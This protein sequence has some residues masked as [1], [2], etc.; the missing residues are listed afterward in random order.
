M[1]SDGVFTRYG[2]QAYYHFCRPHE[3]LRQEYRYLNT[4]GEE[5]VRYRYRTPMMAAGLTRHRWTVR[6]FLLHRLPA[7]C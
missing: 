7:G 1:A 2:F 5:V 6:E 3:S 4:R